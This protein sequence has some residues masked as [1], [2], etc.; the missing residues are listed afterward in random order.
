MKDTAVCFLTHIASSS[1]QVSLMPAY[2]QWIFCFFS[3]LLSTAFLF[4]L[5]VCQLTKV[6]PIS[7]TNSTK[8]KRKT[9]L[10]FQIVH[11]S[12]FI[13]LCCTPICT[14][15]M[16]L[17]ADV[18]LRSGSYKEL[19]V[20]PIFS[21]TTITTTQYTVIWPVSNPLHKNSTHR[22]LAARQRTA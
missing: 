6:P 16:A 10:C 7:W 21:F 13:V 3:V 9:V 22:K 12:L 17:I 8:F 20:V 19:I 2:P 5:C 14:C 11:L 15:C 18:S 1:L 4:L